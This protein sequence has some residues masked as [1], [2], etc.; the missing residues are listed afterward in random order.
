MPHVTANYKMYLPAGHHRQPRNAN[1]ELSLAAPSGGDTPYSPPYF[2]QLPYT[3]PNSAGSGMA[4][5]LFWSDT[6]GSTGII[7]PPQPFDIPSSG[8]ARTVT[9]WYYPI[10]GPGQPGTGSA[11]IDDAFSA[12]QGAFINDTFVDVTSDPSLTADANVVGVVPTNVLQTLL[13]HTQVLSTPEPFSQWILNDSLMPVGNTA[14]TLPQGTDGIAIAVYQQGSMPK[15]PRLD[16]A[17]VIRI[18]YGVIQDGGG[19]TD[20][21]P[22]DPWGPLLAKLANSGTIAQRAA[23]MDRKIGAETS[24]LAAQDALTAIRLALP[25][26]EKLAGKSR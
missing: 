12:A 5:L 14:L 3:L 10:S 22:I 6:D 4:K 23:A 16:Y 26:L 18:L 15:A 24:Q 13:A 8:T 2:P 19:L 9:G 20:H 11:I 1:A 25:A 21:G 7:R 17:E